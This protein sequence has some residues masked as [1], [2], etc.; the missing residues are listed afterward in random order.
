MRP[1]DLVTLNEQIASMARAGLPLD[2]GLRS[3]ASDL[4]SGRLKRVTLGLSEELRQGANL[5]EAFDRWQSDLP[6]HYAGIAEAGIRTGRLPDVLQTLTR[7]A[8][9]IVEMRST[10]LAAMIYPILVVIVAVGVLIG[11][12]YLQRLLSETLREFQLQLPK[13]T[14]A[15][16]WLGE[17]LE[18]TLGIPLACIAIGL[19]IV[20][21]LRR[22]EGGCIAWTN[23]VYQVPLVGSLVRS[24]RLAAFVDLLAGMVEYSMPLPEAF[25]LA[26]GATGDPILARQSRILSQR[27]AEGEAF[28]KAIREQ[29]LLP[30]WTA[31]MAMVGERQG[32][33][34][35]TLREVAETY[36]RQVAVRAEVI[37][38]VVP[39]LFVVIV[40]GVVGLVFLLVV[41]APFLSLIEGLSK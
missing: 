32:K 11:L 13:A 7:H 40:G 15:T 4:Q 21:A 22:T 26:G 18:W 41:F 2:Q 12:V 17:H 38:N 8:R 25:R 33:L 28:G 16:I 14:R 10:I 36:R 23:F 6:P 30:E 19:V 1:D 37:K 35:E 27:L 24:A 20:W 29:R 39:S 31:W 34:A 5:A 9:S 3:L